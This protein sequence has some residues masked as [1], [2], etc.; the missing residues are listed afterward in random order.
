ML[1][2][3]CR[4][5]LGLAMAAL[6]LLWPTTASSQVEPGTFE[7]GGLQRSYRLHLPAHAP[8]PWPLVIV[9]HGFGGDGE[10]VLQQ[11]RWVE[12]SAAAG[13]AVLAPDGSVEHE[14]RAARFIGN[15]RSW[16]SGAGTGSPAQQRGVD[17]IGFVRAL[18]DELLHLQPL[19]PSRI[20][21]T[22]FSNGAAMAFRVGLEMSER[23]AAIAPVA[24]SLLVPPQPL[25]RPVSLL[26]IWGSADPLNPMEG[27]SVTRSSGVVPRPS[28]K[29]SWH[30]WSGL[31]HC[32][33]E[34]T[35]TALSDRVALRAQRHCD[36]GASSQWIS[37]D[38]LAHQWPGG[39][40]YLRLISG[41]GSD[42]IDA[43]DQIWRFFVE[44]PRR[45]P[46]AQR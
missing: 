2:H 6:F 12:K 9:F 41:P 3:I 43:T 18:L 16:N 37:V 22:G 27:G 19:D 4:F 20:Y 15:P 46:A 44:Q 36:G 8:Q 40:T 30:T 21:A 10:N 1:L 34:P 28:A 26:L 25:A 29:D 38:G 31:L 24:N 5:F 17:D 39:R 7:F 23:I 45:Q 13:F 42:A 11:G 35:Q 14:N 32:T 33:G